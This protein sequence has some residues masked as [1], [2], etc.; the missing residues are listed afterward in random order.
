MRRRGETVRTRV[1]PGP[2]N[3]LGKHWL[4][5]SVP[6]YGIHGTTAPASIYTFQTHG[7]IRLHPDDIA[8]LF[9]QAHIGMAGEIIYAPVL[10]YA[11][12]HDILL[13]AHPD[14]YRRATDAAERVAAAAAELGVDDH[15]DW[16]AVI[17]VL[18]VRDGRP[19]PV[20][21]DALAGGGTP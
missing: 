13:E 2:A 10:L 8:A 7:C 5:L 21:L 6:G 17:E 9:D 3:P 4:G 19:H 1:E 11:A 15:I 16:T 18:R 20:R 12:G 14:V